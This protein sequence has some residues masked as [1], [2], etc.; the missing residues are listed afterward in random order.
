VLEAATDL[1]IAE[2]GVATM[3]ALAARAG[4][5][6]T[7]VHKWWPSPTAV[8]LD[9]LLESPSVRPTT[10]SCTG[11]RPWTLPSKSTCSRSSSKGSSADP[12]C[13]LRGRKEGRR[14]I[15]WQQIDDALDTVQSE[16]A[17]AELLRTEL[18]ASAVPAALIRRYDGRATFRC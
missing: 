14:M 3:E 10:G 15:S 12:T 16:V 7:T 1:T 11:T 18:A 8:A 17:S 4:V 5:S 2:Q 13:A 9:G 6:R